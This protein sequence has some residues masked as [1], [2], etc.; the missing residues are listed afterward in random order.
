MLAIF[1]IYE[2]LAKNVIFPALCINALFSSIKLLLIYYDC[3]II[4]F[5]WIPRLEQICTIHIHW[6]ISIVNLAWN[7]PI[8]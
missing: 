7:F 6:P 5:L 4:V 3:I 8:L 1:L 2:W